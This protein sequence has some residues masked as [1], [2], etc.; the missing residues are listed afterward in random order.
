MDDTSSSDVRVCSQWLKRL[1][2]EYVWMWACYVGIDLVWWVSGWV[3]AFSAM[4]FKI[5]D[6]GGQESSVHRDLNVCTRRLL[7]CCSPETCE[8]T[9][10]S[11]DIR[12]MHP[13]P[14]GWSEGKWTT[15]RGRW[16]SEEGKQQTMTASVQNIT[17]T[18]H[19]QLT[20]PDSLFLSPG[21]PR[22]QI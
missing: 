20:P 1:K 10:G 7:V 5:Y 19:I 16:K 17:S 4:S 13:C 6:V 11:L 8:A 3:T 21:A 22:P 12:L 18:L 2:S 15:K 9:H 14:L